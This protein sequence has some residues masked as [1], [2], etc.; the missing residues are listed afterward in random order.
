MNL[1]FLDLE[2]TVIASW[3]DQT[4][5]PG[6]IAHIKEFLDGATAH[7]GVE[8]GLASWAVW[9][10]RDKSQFNN[11]LRE[12][13]EN[14]LGH[15]FDDRFVWSMDDWAKELF[16]HTGKL[17]ERSELFDIFGK[18]EVLIKMARCHPLF[19]DKNV[20]L[21]DDRVEH[22]LHIVSPNNRSQLLF[23]NILQSIKEN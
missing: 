14:A 9:N 11:N 17:M 16:V 15:K 10:D 5:L 12:D 20:L 2:E 4:L 18:E 23:V 7:D 13:L 3:D 21:F 8:I 19:S 6:R 1:V 22:N